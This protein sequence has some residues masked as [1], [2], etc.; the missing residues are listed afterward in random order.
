MTPT[1]PTYN[2]D[3]DFHD[4]LD[5][6]VR[7]LLSS[8]YSRFPGVFDRIDGFVDLAERDVRERDDHELR[9]TPK[10]FYLLEAIN[11]KVYDE[12]NRKLF[13]ATGHTLII[14]PD[15][16]S[17]HNSDCQKIDGKWGDECLECTPDCQAHE[18]MQLVASYG[19]QVFFS[20]RKLSEQL[21]HYKDRSN[22]L[23][24]IGIACLLMLADGMRTAMDLGIPVRGVPLDFC[25]CDHWNDRPFASAFP[26]K[27]LEAILKEKYER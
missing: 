6:F 9:R 12:Y 17:L 20:K 10:P 16:L 5:S 25:G 1:P 18:V 4:K 15:C 14:L 7:D 21:G 23:G 26:M 22:N 3:A 24:V 8:G 19:A 11:Y 27:R 13:N 2:L